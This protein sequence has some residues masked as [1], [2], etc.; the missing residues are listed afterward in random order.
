M[1]QQKMKHYTINALAFFK[2]H[3]TLLLNGYHTP[4]IFLSKQKMEL[5]YNSTMNIIK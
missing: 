5:L 4:F 3:K 2:Q 1:A